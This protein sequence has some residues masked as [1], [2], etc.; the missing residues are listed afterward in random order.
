MGSGDL[1][2]IA[3]YDWGAQGFSLGVSRPECNIHGK[4]EFAYLK[5]IEDLAEIIARFLS[6]D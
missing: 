6:P 3:N 4:D 1:P 5:D 2:H